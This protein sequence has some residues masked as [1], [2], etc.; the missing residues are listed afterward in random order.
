MYRGTFYKRIHLVVTSFVQSPHHQLE[1]LFEK[2]MFCWGGVQ[3]LFHNEKWIVAYHI[4]HR[5][6][7]SAHIQPPN[8]TKYDI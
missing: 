1:V 6:L 8:Y 4:I 7:H 2:R 3:D 5:F